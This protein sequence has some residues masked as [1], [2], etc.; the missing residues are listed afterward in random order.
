MFNNM[1]VGTRLVISYLFMA[2]VV[3]VTG[4]LGIHYTGSVGEEGVDVGED[5][6]PLGDAAMEIK[7][8][9]TQAHLLMEEILSGDDTENVEEVYGLLDESLWYANAILNGGRNGEGT[10]TATH[11]EEVR[12]KIMLVRDG[13]L[14]FKESAKERY[15]NRDDG[16]AAGT[17]S[18]ARFDHEFELF[19]RLAD[20]AETAVHR[21]MAA[22][23]ESLRANSQRA[24][25]SMTISMLLGVAVAIAAGLLMSRSITQPIVRVAELSERIAKG[26]LS[27]ASVSEEEQTSS[28]SRSEIVVLQRSSRRMASRLRELV[29]QLQSG[30]SQLGSSTS[31][32]ATTAKEAAAAAAQQS[33]TVTEV[34]TTMD[35]I[36]T[37]SQAAA[38]S[39]QEVVA[40][41]ERVAETGQDGLRAVDRA[42]TL[43]NAIEERV[44]EIAERILQLSEQNKQ[45]GEIV[46]TVN[47]LS[48]QSNLLAVN[49]SIEAAKAGEHGRGFAVVAS[50][51][52]N[53]AEQS[54]RA[55]QQIRGI[56]GDIQKAT[57][58]AVMTTEEGTKRTK[59]GLGAITSVRDVI[60]DLARTLE[61]SADRVRQIAGN[62]SQQ[63]TG[64]QQIS[65]A[66]N[67]LARSGRENAS[68][69]GN[70]ERA[71]SDIRG[72]AEQ[73]KQISSG[74]RL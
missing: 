5:L 72:L 20:E 31:E 13:L 1:R 6:A 52:R 28:E 51:V 4:L 44:R 35:E 37:T 63:A 14:R 45:I 57:Q 11:S 18:D 69:A 23:L 39:A 34:S 3:C 68:G 65:Q 32:I 27:L 9:A 12:E 36:Q 33:V 54:K 59:D 61:D 60:T 26:D 55:T 24:E 50:E 73:L 53:L 62:A 15:S 58:T 40:A 38:S 64:I 17:E 30:I 46:E 8:S 70:L 43:M 29:G 71:A 49:A 67:D 19:M 16:V 41:A 74:Y 10:Y 2:L 48:E 25:V 42:V 56:L 21:D 7:L 22:G 47:D 66:I